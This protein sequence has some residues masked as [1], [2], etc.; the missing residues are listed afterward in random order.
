MEEQSIESADT[1]LE[2]WFATVKHRHNIDLI[3]GYAGAEFFIVEGDSLLRWVFSDTRID[4]DE[5][6][7]LLHAVFVV[8][9]FLQRLKR[10]RCNFALVFFDGL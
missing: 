7:Q 4:F 8:E 6:F 5:G 2:T 9:E 1:G 3:E 10:R